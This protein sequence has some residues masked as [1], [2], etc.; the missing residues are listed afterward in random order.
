MSALTE[1]GVGFGDQTALAGVSTLTWRPPQAEKRE[2]PGHAYA[3]TSFCWRYILGGYIPPVFG[4]T[5]QE[6]PGERVIRGTLQLITGGTR[7]C[8][9][10][11]PPSGSGVGGLAPLGPLSGLSGLGSA[12][13]FTSTAVAARVRS[14]RGERPTRT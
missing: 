13:R 10:V 9:E 14:T 6:R 2:A 8:L 4:F 12:Y 1:R 3:V 7:E 11:T 5:C